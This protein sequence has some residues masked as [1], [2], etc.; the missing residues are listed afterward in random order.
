MREIKVTFAMIVAILVVTWIYIMTYKKPVVLKSTA[1]A[2]AQLQPIPLTHIYDKS[3]AWKVV[4][5]FEPVDGA[6]SLYVAQAHKPGEHKS[7]NRLVFLDRGSCFGTRNTTMI[8]R[9]GDTIGIMSVE[10]R[11]GGFLNT[12]TKKPASFMAFAEPECR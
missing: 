1:T 12:V 5:Q 3:E 10:V 2:A 4:S 6:H 9:I 7:V 11:A 8:P